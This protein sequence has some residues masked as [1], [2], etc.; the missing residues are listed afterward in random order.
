MQTINHSIIKQLVKPEPDSHKG[1][2]G[3]VLVIAGSEKYHGALLLGLQTVSR[4]VDMVYVYT[5]PNNLELVEKLKSEMAVF[6]S[7]KEK[8]LKETINLVDAVLVGPG[9]EESRENKKLV[10]KLLKKYPEKKVIIDATAIWQ[11]DPS[12]LHENCVLTPHS[13]EFEQIF[14]CDPTPDNVLKM[15]KY[16]GCIVVLKGRYDYV[17]DGQELYQNKT[18]NV[19]MTKG[20][21]GDIVSGVVTGLASKNS[22]LTSALAGIYLAGVAGDKLYD[23]YGTFYNAEDMVKSLGELW[24]DELFN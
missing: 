24:K 16:Y 6:I 19:G 8:E 2:N 5:T 3:R 21:T 11:L 9:L 13:R 10:E 23:K 22:L 12:I 7:V 15:A 14:N 4:V 1:Q 20:G 17:S 18:G